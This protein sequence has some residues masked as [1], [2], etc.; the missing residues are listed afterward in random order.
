MYIALLYQ[1]FPDSNC[2][3]FQITKKYLFNFQNLESKE[4]DGVFS[5][6]SHTIL[7]LRYMCVHIEALTCQA[8]KGEWGKV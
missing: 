4:M 7:V 5:Q 1:L 6:I 8:E 2:K 3:Q